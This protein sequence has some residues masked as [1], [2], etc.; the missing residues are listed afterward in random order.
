VTV[1]KPSKLSKIE[2]LEVKRIT[3][4]ELRYIEGKI[5]GLT[6]L[7]TEKI[8]ELKNQNGIPEISIEAILDGVDTKITIE[9]VKPEGF[10]LIEGSFRGIFRK[11]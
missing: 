8:N 5:S 1:Y 9:D 3:E 4:G 6:P 7:N 10:P 11:P 2:R